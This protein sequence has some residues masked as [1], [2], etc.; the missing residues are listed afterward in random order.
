MGHGSLCRALVR[1]PLRG[2][3]PSCGSAGLRA[4]K[5]L[6][7]A[8]C[9]V[10]QN[11]APLYPPHTM[12]P[13]PVAEKVRFTIAVDQDVYDAF[14]E[15]A[16]TSGVSM[17]RCIG[18][19]LRDTAEAAQMTTLKVRDARRSPQDA[20]HAFLMSMTPEIERLMR[21][22]PRN[23]WGTA[24]RRARGGES[25]SEQAQPVAAARTPAPPIPPSSNT[26]GK[27]PKKGKR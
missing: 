21:E 6:L 16:H 25:G 17:S 14:A 3:P 2:C 10:V 9:R 13:V 18:D 22:G 20:L 15:L 12:P 7:H 27:S 1:V 11:G 4:I 26:G 19:W 5:T 8:W 24:A 23:A